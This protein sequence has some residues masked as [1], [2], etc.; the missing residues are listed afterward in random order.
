MKTVTAFAEI[1]TD[2]HRNSHPCGSAEKG[3]PPAKL[4]VSDASCSVEG[5]PLLGTKPRLDRLANYRSAR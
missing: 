5:G 3:G 1:P 2:A 4:L